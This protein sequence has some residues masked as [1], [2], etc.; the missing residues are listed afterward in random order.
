[1]CNMPA[2]LLQHQLSQSQSPPRGPRPTL[3]ARPRGSCQRVH[4]RS[5]SF[6]R[7]THASWHMGGPP[8]PRASTPRRPS[9]PPR[10]AGDSGGFRAAA[11]S[12]QKYCLS[13]F[14][15]IHCSSSLIS[16]GV[17]SAS[18]DHRQQGLHT[19]SASAS[20][21]PDLIP[22]L[23]KCYSKCCYV[24]R[25]VDVPIPRISRAHSHT[26]IYRHPSSSSA[27]DLEAWFRR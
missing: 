5:C 24:G 6:M 16:S 14:S 19:P 15:Y 17:H 27:S 26:S 10:S 3:Q 22:R 7:M 2:A 1:V 20:H 21:T 25:C 9:G 4:G 12:T 23:I 11:T 8:P 18:P 13:K